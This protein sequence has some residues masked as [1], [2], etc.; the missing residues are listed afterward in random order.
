M[1]FVPPINWP[2]GSFVQDGLRIGPSYTNS[3]QSFNTDAN[4]NYIIGNHTKYGPGVLTSPFNT[5]DIVPYP[6]TTGNIV[7]TLAVTTGGDMTFSGDGAAATKLLGENGKAY[8]QMDWPRVPAVVVAGAAMSGPTTVTIFGADWYGFPLQHAYTV[9]AVGTYPLTLGTPAKAFYK[10]TRINV[11]GT[12]G[13]GGTLSVRTS[14]TFGLP[15]FLKET[16]YASN[17]SWNGTSFNN[18]FGVAT[19]VSGNVVVSTPAI[20]IL[21][22][23]V[24]LS[25]KSIAGTAGFLQ[26]SVNTDR[27]SFTINSTNNADGSDVAW[28]IPNG[29]QNLLSA[30]STAV[31]TATTGDVRGLVKLPEAGETWGA[32]PDGVRRLVF[33][34]YVSGSNNF[35]NQLAAGSQPQGAGTV[36]FLKSSDLYGVEQYYTGIV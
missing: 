1:V 16:S 14:N 3:T 35:Q 24:L 27:V 11:N 32:A 5:W 25:H 21:G 12:T 34:P 22:S 8:I 4:G 36:P 29:G 7:S 23:S 33:T 31:A 19:L 28:F 9:Q 26:Y 2:L 6:S 30:G 18:Q 17:F 10:I 20:R 13:I 15:Y